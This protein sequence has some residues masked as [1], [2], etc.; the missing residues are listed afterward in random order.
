MEKFRNKYRIPSTRL[1]TWDYGWN[2]S[3]FVTICTHMRICYFG[4]IESG[5]MHFSE[6]GSVAERLWLE[7]PE[8]FPFVQLSEFV[9]MPN[10]V[11]G[12]IIINKTIVETQNFAS[13]QS[14]PTRPGIPTQSPAVTKTTGLP[15]NRF[16]PQTQNLASIIRGYKTGVKKYSYLKTPEF[17]WQSRFHDHIIRNNTEY[18]R[19]K[20]YIINN[21]ANWLNDN[22]F[23]S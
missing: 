21:P 13:L 14:P 7:I 23:N 15:K 16:G 4:I 12:I 8:H 5:V 6:L 1:Q 2:G 17:K 19:I 10:H 9:I 22:F 18:E 11:H 3:Y 20:K